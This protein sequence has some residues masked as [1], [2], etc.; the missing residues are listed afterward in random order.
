M[1]QQGLRRLVPLPF[2]VSRDDTPRLNRS[3][4]RECL[5]S[6]RGVPEDEHLPM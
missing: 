5:A 6:A 3:A 1:S 4:P 2:V